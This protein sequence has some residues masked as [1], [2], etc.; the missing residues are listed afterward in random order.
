MREGQA[1]KQRMYAQTDLCR[2]IHCCVLINFDVERPASV[3]MESEPRR[4]RVDVPH[5]RGVLVTSGNSQRGAGGS[6]S[7]E[8]LSI[9]SL[10][11]KE[12]RRF[13]GWNRAFAEAQRPDKAPVVLF[14]LGVRQAVR[15]VGLCIIRLIHSLT[16]VR[17]RL[18]IIRVPK[19]E[20]KTKT[21]KVRGANKCGARGER[22]R[23]KR[24]MH[25]R[26]ATR[27]HANAT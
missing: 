11:R 17:Q 7:V 5:C 3:G 23:A 2:D 6:V 4:V 16:H 14:A 15:R 12:L 13:G 1:N 10:E 25:S 24:R 22:R 27:A 19:A 9:A 21:N 18:N 8:A 20:S 26:D